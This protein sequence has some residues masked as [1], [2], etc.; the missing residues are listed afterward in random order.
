MI[1]LH[2]FFV[3]LRQVMADEQSI[4]RLCRCD[5]CRTANGT[6]DCDAGLYVLKCVCLPRLFAEHFD[7]VCAANNTYPL[8]CSDPMTQATDTS[9]CPNDR[10]GRA[11]LDDVFCDANGRVTELYGLV[12]VIRRVRVFAATHSLLF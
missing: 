5:H 4:E 11:T 3:H 2:F 12:D 7:A 8:W 10:M 9:H 1:Y 6:D